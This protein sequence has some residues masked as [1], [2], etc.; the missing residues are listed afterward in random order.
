M[1]L[2]VR[3]STEAVAENT[4][5]EKKLS[6]HSESEAALQ[7]TILIKIGT[8]A[9]GQRAVRCSGWLDVAGLT[10]ERSVIFRQSIAKKIVVNLSDF[11]SSRGVHPDIDDNCRPRLGR[12]TS[13]LS[14]KRNARFVKSL[15]QLRGFS[16][17]I[18][19]EQHE[20]AF[21]RFV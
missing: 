11:A 14:A 6:Q 9:Q 8:D 1:A 10:K 16:R 2:N 18:A 19:P 3:T 4:I 17:R 15:Q 13:R 21:F 5:F 20:I 7:L 12:R